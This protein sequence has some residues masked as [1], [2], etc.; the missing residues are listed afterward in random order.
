MDPEAK[1]DA[2]LDAK[3]LINEISSSKKSRRKR[4]GSLF[5]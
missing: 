1:R 3:N 5:I 2:L 4:G